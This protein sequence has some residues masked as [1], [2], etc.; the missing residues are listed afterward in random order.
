MTLGGRSFGHGHASSA[1]GAL[2][3]VVET[4]WMGGRGWR[5]KSEGLAGL[6]W[7]GLGLRR[8]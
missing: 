8:V 3:S 2:V 5:R 7:T 1:E 4:G 6:I